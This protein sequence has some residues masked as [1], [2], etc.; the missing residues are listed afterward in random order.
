MA[1]HSSAD[2]GIIKR[3]HGIHAPSSARQP[4]IDIDKKKAAAMSN[5]DCSGS[6]IKQIRADAYP[7]SASSKKTIHDAKRIMFI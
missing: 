4:F 5:T 2:N 7:S 1:P 3:P 6:T